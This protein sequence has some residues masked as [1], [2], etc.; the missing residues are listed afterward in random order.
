[1]GS[2][3]SRFLAADEDNQAGLLMYEDELDGEWEESDFVDRDEAEEGEGEQQA[4]QGDS[5]AAGAGD[6]NQ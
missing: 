5:S 6:S 1:M 3:F 2:G 4:G